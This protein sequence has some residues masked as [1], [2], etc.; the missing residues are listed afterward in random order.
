MMGMGGM[1]MFPFFPIIVLVLILYFVFGQDKWRRSGSESG[2]S[3]LEI[4]KK[5]YAK[6]EISK[7]EFEETRKDLLS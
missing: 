4:L 2:D 5:R 1:W 7:E 3:A 6:G